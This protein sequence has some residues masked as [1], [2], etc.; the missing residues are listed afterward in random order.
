MK[1]TL[2]FA[3]LMSAAFAIPT[4]STSAAEVVIV[5]A[6]ESV[7]AVCFVLPLLP[8]CAAQWNDY[9]LSKGYHLTTPYAW[10]TCRPAGD[11]AGHLLECETN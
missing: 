5:D 7:D 10:W 3:A 8:D 2:I 1:K 4:V 6:P 11:G 9:W